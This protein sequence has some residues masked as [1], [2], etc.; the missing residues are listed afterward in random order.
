[1]GLHTKM[2]QM[3]YSNRTSERYQR[4]IR[5]L[6]YIIEK[7]YILTLVLVSVCS[8]FVLVFACWVIL[9][10]PQRN[11]SQVNERLWNAH[12]KVSH[13][14]KGKLGKPTKMLP[15]SLPRAC[16]E[17]LQALCKENKCFKV[18]F[19][20]FSLHAECLGFSFLDGIHSNP[21]H[22]RYSPMHAYLLSHQG[23][24]LSTF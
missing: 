9:Q 14:V 3:S 13:R 19:S 10:Q 17:Q 7:V 11:S 8:L 12:I 23:A 15:C 20:P 4:E 5:S 22:Q 1:M 2:L 16:W 24:H 6:L 21:G 18:D